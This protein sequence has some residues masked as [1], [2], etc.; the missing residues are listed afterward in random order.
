MNYDRGNKMNT[1]A[2][3]KKGKSMGSKKSCGS[4]EVRSAIRTQVSKLNKK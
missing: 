2:S 1:G 3:Y 4:P